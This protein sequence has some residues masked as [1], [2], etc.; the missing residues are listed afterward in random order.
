MHTLQNLH[1]LKPVSLH[2]SPGGSLKPDEVALKSKWI[3][4]DLCLLK[5]WSQLQS[6]SFHSA[7]ALTRKIQLTRYGFPWIWA[8]CCAEVTL[9]HKGG[10]PAELRENGLC[11]WPREVL[12]KHQL[13]H[14]DLTYDF[15]RIFE[16]QSC[17]FCNEGNPKWRNSALQPAVKRLPINS[18][19][20]SVLIRRDSFYLLT[21][22]SL[23]SSPSGNCFLQD[24]F[25]YT[26]TLTY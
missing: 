24:S 17:I 18:L 14:R 22:P 7:A 21:A 9:F 10:T 13:K 6:R 5:E 26:N 23:L 20:Q 2:N 15:F 25:R 3:S 11:G 1:R 8:C 16:A 12:L 4:V 19:L